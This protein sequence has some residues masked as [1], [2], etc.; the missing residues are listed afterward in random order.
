M[1]LGSRLNN[2]EAYVFGI[3]FCRRKKSIIFGIALGKT[4]YLWE[5][6]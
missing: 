1:K 3:V 2:Q 6:K 4:S 5:Y